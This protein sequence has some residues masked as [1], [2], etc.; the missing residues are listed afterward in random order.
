[1]KKGEKFD[2]ESFE[3]KRLENYAQ[4]KS[5]LDDKERCPV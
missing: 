3:K 4:E 1:M 5:S 2:F